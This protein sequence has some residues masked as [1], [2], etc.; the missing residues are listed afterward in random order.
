MSRRHPS[1]PPFRD[2]ALLC[3]I[4]SILL[5]YPDDSVF[6]RLATVTAALP[7]IPDSAAREALAGFAAWLA[8]GTPIEAAQHYVATFDHTRR[9]GMYLTYYRHGDTRARGMAL[10]ALKHTYRTAG[11]VPP[12]DELPDFLP[13]VLEFASAAPEPGERVLLQCQPGLELLTDAVRGTGSPYTAPLDVVRGCLPELGPAR[14]KELRALAENGPPAEQVG[15]EPF[16]PP[17]YL[18]GGRL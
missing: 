16:A 3:R 4:T 11:Y 13:L 14:R 12:E 1:P 2:T 5:R 18:A 15:L 17:E 9:R 6:A 10:L 8:G 7:S